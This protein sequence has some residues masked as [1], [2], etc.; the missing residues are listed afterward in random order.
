[1]CERKELN[2]KVGDTILVTNAPIFSESNI[3]DILELTTVKKITPTGR[4]R[5]TGRYGDVQFDKYGVEMNRA[6]YKKTKRLLL[7]TKKDIAKAEKKNLVAEIFVKLASISQQQYYNA[8][9]KKL[10][11][12]NTLLDVF[13]SE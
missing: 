11:E 3:D 9:T 2:V 4:I 13:I 5:V 12:L 7:P 1:M 10:V 6:L 8:D